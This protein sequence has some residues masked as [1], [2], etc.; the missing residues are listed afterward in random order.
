MNSLRYSKSPLT[1]TSPKSLQFLN[2]RH[3]PETSHCGRPCCKATLLLR[4]SSIF[5]RW[6]DFLTEV[7]T[8]PPML[9]E[10]LIPEKALHS[11]QRQT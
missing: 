9:V 2:E 4:L 3:K 10:D 8:P 1:K 11:H 5:A 7:G 6:E